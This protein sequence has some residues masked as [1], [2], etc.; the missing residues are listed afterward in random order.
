MYCSVLNIPNG[1][2]VRVVLIKTYDNLRVTIAVS[3][4]LNVYDN[5]KDFYRKNIDSMKTFT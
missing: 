2:Y 1:N 3:G 5:F 4:V